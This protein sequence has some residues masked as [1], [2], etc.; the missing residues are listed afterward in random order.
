MFSD[1]S[2]GQNI[3]DYLNCLTYPSWRQAPSFCRVDYNNSWDLSKTYNDY[4]TAP[5]RIRF[6]PGP[7][8][9]RSNITFEIR[10]GTWRDLTQN[11]ITS[12]APQYLPTKDVL[13]YGFSYLNVMNGDNI[14]PLFFQN[15]TGYDI[16]DL[17]AYID[18]HPD[19]IFFLW[20]TS[21]ARGIGTGVSESFNNA[22]REYA[23]SH[24]IPLFDL[25][26]IESHTDLGAACYDNRD[27]IVFRTENYPDD[28][29]NI[30]AICQD[31]TTEI[32]GG[33]LGSVSGG[34]IR[35]SK[36]F[37]VLLARLAGWNP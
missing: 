26:D 28:G 33:H 19:K 35:T 34:G 20:T 30:P 31:W 7:Q 11:F 22:M 10:T 17:Q 6:L 2:V 23:R 16:Y 18:A 1:R 4:N 5:Q 36:A 3:Y 14:Y 8:Y 12:L 9:S 15:A 13:S 37:W 29:L 27:G 32:D 21:L 24:H 25:A